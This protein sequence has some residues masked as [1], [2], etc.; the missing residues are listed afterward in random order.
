MV[1]YLRWRVAAV[2]RKYDELGEELF[3]LRDLLFQIEG[4]AGG[5]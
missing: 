1:K 3:W 2:A 5:R 4:S